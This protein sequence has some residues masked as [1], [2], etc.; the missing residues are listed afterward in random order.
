MKKEIEVFVAKVEAEVNVLMNK[1]YPKYANGDSNAYD[2][3]K[4]LSVTFG[5]KYAK[6]ISHDAN[7]SGGSVWGFVEIET[8]ALLKA[9]GWNKP[10]KHARGNIATATLGPN[11]GPYGPNYLK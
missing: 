7:G 9:A 2:P 4:R 3:S 1:D 11:Y 8:G 5:R 6:I 10:A